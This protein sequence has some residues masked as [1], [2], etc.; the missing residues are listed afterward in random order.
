V[1]LKQAIARISNGDSLSSVEIRGVMQ[2]IMRGEATAAQIGGLLI[3]LRMK[4]ETVEEI[5]GAALAMREASSRIHPKAYPLTDTCGT[6]GDGQNTFN[7]STT[8][9]LVA[10]GAG[11]NI[12]KHGNRAMS[13]AV[14]G[15]DVLE[16]LGVR[17]DLTP[18]QVQECID[19]VGIGFLFA[20][21]FH[22]SMRYVA[23]PRRDL[24]VR[25]LFNL[26]GPLCNPAG[27]T[28]QVVG[29]FAARWINPLAQA[30]AELGAEHVL[31]VHSA[32]GLDEIALSAPTAVTEWK[33]GTLHQFELQPEQFGFERCA[34]SELVVTDA[35]QSARLI[36]DVLNAVPGPHRDV[37]L[38]NAGA[39]I[40]VAG[41]ADSIE[42]GISLAR[43]SIDS[44]RAR[45]SL[46][47]LSAFVPQ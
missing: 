34:I 37:V 13:G 23:T 14:G 31:V 47:H 8:A 21:T 42:D 36:H 9:A 43:R 11:V 32:D 5:V 15:A 12:A 6:G 3:A 35:A 22:P 2:I 44:G 1:D 26:L 46:E 16:T 38:M 40:Y 45:T 39:V 33:D 30:L 27:A 19:R 20:Q 41:V 7:I 29:T 18:E 10:A 24:G 28:R 4:G 17:I 25:T